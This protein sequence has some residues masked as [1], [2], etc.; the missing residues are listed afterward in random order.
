MIKNLWCHSATNVDHFENNVFPGDHF[1]ER[2]GI[3]FWKRG[4]GDDD[5][6]WSTFLPHGVDCI[7]TKVRKHLEDLRGIGLD[8]VVICRA[9]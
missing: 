1:R 3:P 6:Y 8:D 2:C 5:I 4:F 9:L 7:C